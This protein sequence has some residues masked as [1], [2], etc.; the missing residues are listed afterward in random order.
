MI[1]DISRFDN[2]FSS[3]YNRIRNKLECYLK[4]NEDAFHDTYLFIRVNLLFEKAEITDFEPYF[5]GC[6]KKISLKGVKREQR[7]CHP[8]DVFFQLLS[9]SEPMQ[10]EDLL[11]LDK[12]AH[13]IL[14]FVKAKFS[15]NEYRLFKLRNFETGCSYKDLSDYT[16][17]SSSSIH[18]KVSSV[19]NAVRMNSDFRQRNSQLIAI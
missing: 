5:I 4:L 2:W 13:D 17:I 3:S 1:R 15:E 18:K 10:I 16:G 8:E 12:L 9:E 6:Y 7:Y 11:A 14:K 19:T